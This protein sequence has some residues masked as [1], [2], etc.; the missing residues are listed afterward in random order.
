MSLSASDFDL[1]HIPTT[2]ECIRSSDDS[3]ID[4]EEGGRTHSQ[5]P[6]ACGAY[7]NVADTQPAEQSHTDQILDTL[8]SIE[9]KL[10]QHHQ[11]VQAHMQEIIDALTGITEELNKTCTVLD[12]FTRSLMHDPTFK[13]QTMDPPNKLFKRNNGTST[14]AR[15]VDFGD[16]KRWSEE[17][18]KNFDIMFAR[19][20]S[21]PAST[22]ATSAKPCPTHSEPV[23]TDANCTD[24][25]AGAVVVTDVNCIAADAAADF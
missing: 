7:M 9:A 3:H 11:A 8:R 14:P 18:N 15:R 2:P 10:D 22:S 16:F 12:M 23:V 19:L 21:V 25:A 6:A 17:T 1:G 24:A 4:F 20:N 5:V 13:T